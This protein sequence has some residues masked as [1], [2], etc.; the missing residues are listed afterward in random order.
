MTTAQNRFPEFAARM[1]QAG[2]PDAAIRAFESSY[3]ALIAGETG[4]IPEDSI[5]PVSDLPCLENL[6]GRT[7]ADPALLAQTVVIKLNGGLGTSM[8]LERAKSLLTLKDGLTFLDFIV[9]QILE[10]RR[11]YNVPLRF[12]LMNSFSTSADTLDFLR[13]YPDLGDPKSMELMQNQV[14][15]VDAKTLR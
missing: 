15:K 13:R 5:Q 14:P 3:Q 10:L 6:T 4:L 9:R 1:H 12:L 7:S 8:G 2:L 11:R